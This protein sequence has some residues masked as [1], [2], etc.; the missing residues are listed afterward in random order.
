MDLY[1]TLSLNHLAAKGVRMDRLAYRINDFT[2]AVG[3]SRST[4][5]ELIKNGELRAVHI[6]GRTLIPAS[7]AKRLI[8]EACQ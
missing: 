6:G 7:E 4:V 1:G 5:Y 3:L 2:S 8:G